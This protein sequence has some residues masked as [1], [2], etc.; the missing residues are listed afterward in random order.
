MS[1]IK[2]TQARATGATAHKSQ[3]ASPPPPLTKDESQRKL[4]SDSGQSSRA[5]GYAASTSC[6][7]TSVA[8][9]IA[10]TLAVA[11][12]KIN[13]T[14]KRPWSHWPCVRGCSEVRS[15]PPSDARC[16][17]LPRPRR[18]SL[19]WSCARTVWST[20][21]RE[22]CAGLCEWCM[23]KRQRISPMIISPTAWFRH[24]LTPN[25]SEIHGLGPPLTP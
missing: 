1:G 10:A 17:A 6:E 20:I 4:T 21:G 18:R 22:G 25:V 15:P 7:P 13:A 8:S 12:A 11:K 19:P 14:I 9:G 3:A 24:P 16:V 5:P 23:G 2:K